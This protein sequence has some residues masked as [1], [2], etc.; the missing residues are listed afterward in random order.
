MNRE[1]IVP[2][3]RVRIR[4]RADQ[5]DLSSYAYVL[6]V[7]ENMGQ[8]VYVLYVEIDNIII[9]MSRDA[10][11]IYLTRCTNNIDQYSWLGAY[12]AALDAG[13]GE[14]QRMVKAILPASVLGKRYMDVD[15]A[16]ILAIIGPELLFRAVGDGKYRAVQWLLAKGVDLNRRNAYDTPSILIAWLN[17]RP[18]MCKLLLE[19]GADP[20]LRTDSRDEM[21]DAT[22]I[23]LLYG[24]GNESLFTM[25]HRRT[26]STL[27]RALCSVSPISRLPTDILRT[28]VL[29][30]VAE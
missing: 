22:K 24:G 9:E 27:V 25:V 7:R 29:P 28:Y 21:D 6:F 1:S 3:A 17:K 11:D 23:L 19:K 2:G 8:R 26:A 5:G 15:D 16:T 13:S 14:L 18:E 30:L 12:V 20:N 4:P 10:V